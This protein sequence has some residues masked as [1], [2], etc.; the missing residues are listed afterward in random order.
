MKIHLANFKEGIAVDVQENYNPKDLDLEFVDLKYTEPLNLR[1]TVEK[2]ID[3]LTFRGSLRS[4]VEHLCGRCLQKIP[5]LVD[6]EFELFYEIK[7][8]EE[9]ETTDDLREILILDHPITFICRKNCKGLCPEC[10]ANLNE[11]TCH[12]SSQMKNHPF[13][14]LKKIWK[15]KRGTSHGKS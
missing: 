14:Q 6:R 7:G 8:K 1:G 15:E 2:S 3:T 5:D 13:E 4:K 10:G 12:C 9:I 11:E